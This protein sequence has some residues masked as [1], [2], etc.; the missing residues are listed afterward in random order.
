M[1]DL[2]SCVRNFWYL[3]CDQ[4]QRLFDNLHRP[5]RLRNADELKESLLASIEHMPAHLAERVICESKGW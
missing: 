5:M 3:S 4:R 2:E 1:I